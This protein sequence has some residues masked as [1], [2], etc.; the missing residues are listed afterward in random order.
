MRCYNRRMTDDDNIAAALKNKSLPHRYEFFQRRRPLHI[1]PASDAP[2]VEISAHSLINTAKA[3]FSPVSEEIDNLE[4]IDLELLEK[5]A[6]PP[7]AFGLVPPKH[8]EV[9]T[10]PETIAVFAKLRLKKLG[11]P[12]ETSRKQ[13]WAETGHFFLREFLIWLIKFVLG[14]L[15]ALWI[16]RKLDLF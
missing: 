2:T 15:V 14:P 9:N 4:I 16:F 13:R 6:Q 8:A 1:G 5:M 12:V 3:D 10:F 7:S 11:V